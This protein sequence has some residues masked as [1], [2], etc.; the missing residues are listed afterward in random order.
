MGNK[1]DKYIDKNRAFFDSEE[2]PTGHQKRFEQK[3]HKQRD[4]KGVLSYLSLAIVSTAA[5]LMFFFLPTPLETGE[6]SS[7]RASDIDYYYD[8]KINELLFQI[9]KNS[10]QDNLA[11]RQEVEKC[12]E[13]FKN[14]EEE[15]E[16]NRNFL[17]KQQY[18][19]ILVNL[20]T[21]QEE[22]LEDISSLIS[23]NQ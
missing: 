3:L 19:A 7:Q 8:M 21:A 23:N 17:D 14:G 12:M 9:N 6:E 15:L 20:K 16:K 2:I 13:Q 10:D 1:L 22:S 5:A 18:L 11:V 4:K